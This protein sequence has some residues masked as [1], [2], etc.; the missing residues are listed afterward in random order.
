MT[1]KTELKTPNRLKS[2]RTHTQELL[3]LE[4]RLLNSG[5]AIIERE[6]EFFNKKGYTAG[7]ID[8]LAVKY[9]ING[10]NMLYIEEKSGHKEHLTKAKKQIHKGM[11]H[12]IDM[13][14][15]DRIFGFYCHKQENKLV[16]VYTK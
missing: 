14:D 6:R 2:V 9:N 5:W 15:P 11:Q 10:M 12:I 13:Y 16:E 7:D 8:L 1:H 3:S 4:E